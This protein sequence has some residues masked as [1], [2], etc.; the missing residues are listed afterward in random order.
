MFLPKTLVREWK[1]AGIPPSLA[2][3]HFTS[4]PSL[5]KES[6]NKDDFTTNQL[7]PIVFKEINVGIVILY[8][9]FKGEFLF[10]EY[11]SSN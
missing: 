3:E 11:G 9:F 1:K 6:A 4:D 7:V 5:K 2:I 8:Q 10:N